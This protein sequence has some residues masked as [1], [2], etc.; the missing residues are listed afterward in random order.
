[1]LSI[2]LLKRMHWVVGAVGSE[3]RQRM[4]LKVTLALKSM[5]TVM[6]SSVVMVMATVKI[7]GAVM[8]MVGVLV[9]VLVIVPVIKWYGMVTVWPR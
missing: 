9:M 8:S 2:L 4:F 5:A 1:M 6:D 7:V 3:I